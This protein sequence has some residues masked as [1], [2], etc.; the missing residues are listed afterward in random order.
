MTKFMW[1]KQNKFEVF[2]LPY[3]I[4]HLILTDFL[5]HEHMVLCLSIMIFELLT[6]DYLYWA[7]RGEIDA[8]RAKRS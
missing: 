4:M 3:N 8:L 7:Q 2:S 1:I 5:P 6:N